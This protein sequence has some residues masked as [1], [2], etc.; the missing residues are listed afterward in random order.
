L[1][2]GQRRAA[3]PT[4]NGMRAPG[5]DVGDEDRGTCVR[6]LIRKGRTNPACTLDDDDS[7]FEVIRS[8]G[9]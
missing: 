1:V 6:W 5:I 8:E 3:D 4:G 2:G 7:P 9:V